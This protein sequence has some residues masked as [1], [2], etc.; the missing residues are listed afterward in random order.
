MPSRAQPAPLDEVIARLGPPQREPL[1]LGNK[2]DAY[3][4]LV[5]ILL[6]VM[7]RSQ[8]RIDRAYE[9]LHRA[10]EGDWSRLLAMRREE[11]DAVLTPLGFVRRRGQQLLDLVARVDTE[12]GGSLDFLEELSDADAI[13]EL[14]SL[15]GVGVKTAKCV[16]MY[17]LGRPVLPVD[18][19][20]LRVAKRLGIAAM[21]ESWS[22][23]DESLEMAVPAELKYDTHVLFVVHGREVCKARG[24]RCGD[25]VLL[26]LCPSGPLPPDRRADYL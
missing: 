4:E 17:S 12:Y 24:A 23:V 26:D 8:P 20:V 9:Q 10:T 6:T 3:D 11:L 13:R 15:P 25:C 1:P 5:Y 19:H 18:V 7:T 16:L 2:P 21:H 22:R 14:K